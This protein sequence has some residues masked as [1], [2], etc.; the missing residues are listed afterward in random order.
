LEEEEQKEGIIYMSIIVVIV[1]TPM[2][3]YLQTM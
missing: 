3:V 2:V 1:Q